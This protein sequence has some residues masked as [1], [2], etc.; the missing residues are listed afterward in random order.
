MN[1]NE[2]VNLKNFYSFENIY[3][4]EDIAKLS[5]LKN[6]YSR[7]DR[8]ENKGNCLLTDLLINNKL[9]YIYVCNSESNSNIA[10]SMTLSK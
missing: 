7:F 2:C 8:Y 6:V 3:T 10:A 5:K 9:E 4:K 1:M